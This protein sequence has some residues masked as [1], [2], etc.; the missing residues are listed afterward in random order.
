MKLYKDSGTNP[1]AS[2]LP[3][4]LQMPIFCALFRLIDQAAK[5]GRARV[6]DREQAAAVRQR[7]AVRVVPISASFTSPTATWRSRSSR[8]SWCWR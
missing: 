8:R 1:F 4:L 6:P 7:R 3:I 2:C 5:H